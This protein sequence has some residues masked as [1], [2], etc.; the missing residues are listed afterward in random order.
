MALRVEKQKQVITPLHVDTHARAHAHAHA[1]AH[2]IHVCIAHAHAHAHRFSENLC[3]V[4]SFV[5]IVVQ[6]LGAVLRATSTIRELELSKCKITSE[7][8]IQNSN[9]YPSG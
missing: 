6:A 3:R 4:N 8:S 1:H 7:V 5:V 2:H 9:T